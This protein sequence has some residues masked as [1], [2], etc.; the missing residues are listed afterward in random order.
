MDVHPLD[1]LLLNMVP[2]IVAPL[3]GDFIP[4]SSNGHR[5]IVA[6]Q[7]LFVEL[8]RPWLYVRQLIGPN[9]HIALPYGNLT[10]EWRLKHLMPKSLFKQF[11]EHARK[12]MP[13]EAAAWVVFNE[14]TTQYRLVTLDVL[15]SSGSHITIDRPQMGEG[16][17]LALDLHSHAH[18]PAFFSAQ[19]DRDDFGETKLAGV[20]GHVGSAHENWCLRLCLLGAFCPWTD[21]KRFLIEDSNH[22]EQMDAT[23][24]AA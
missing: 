20:L 23:G 19:D 6:K 16:D 8:N 9:H 10:N 1:Q 4:L 7:G 3:N 15:S 12:S 14:L 5:T 17:S 18:F 22:E 24:I 2:S 21:F 13:H 11:A